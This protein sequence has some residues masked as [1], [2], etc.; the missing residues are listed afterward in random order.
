MPAID[1]TRLLD[2][3][4]QLRTFGAVEHH[5]RGIIRPSFGT[6]DM[7]ARR[8]LA[9]RF[10]EAGLEV[11]ISREAV[12]FGK[13]KNPGPA[14]LL[15]SHSDS[16][17]TGGWLDGQLGVIYALEA[18]RALA[19]D[20]ATAHLAVDIASWTDEEGTFV[21]CLGSRVFCGQ[22]LSADEQT[23][24]GDKHVTSGETLSVRLWP[25]GAANNA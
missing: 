23:S 22:D 3:L 5:P 17:P 13:S 1:P 9:G 21:G 2:D 14:L 15:G 25:G 18:A 7:E 16:Q 8:W 20:P 12:V 4:R 11:T 6:A 10:E 24:R 19:A